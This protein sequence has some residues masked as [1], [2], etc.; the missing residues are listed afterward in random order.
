V[1]FWLE[2]NSKVTSES[3]VTA[4]LIQKLK[5]FSHCCLDLQHNTAK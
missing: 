5:R 4:D 1:T 2:I 3:A